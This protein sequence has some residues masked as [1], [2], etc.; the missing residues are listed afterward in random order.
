MKNTS[1]LTRAERKTIRAA[2]KAHWKKDLLNYYIVGETNTS[3]GGIT[4]QKTKISGAVKSKFKH[5][6]HPV[7]EWM[8]GEVVRIFG[9][10]G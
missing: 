5:Q 1:G 4:Y 10:N 9:L 7:A 8:F 2:K 3:A 6:D